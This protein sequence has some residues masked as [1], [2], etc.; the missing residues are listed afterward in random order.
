MSI[1]SVHPKCG[2]EIAGQRACHC[3]ACC[4]TFSGISLFDAHRSLRGGEHG[5][6]LDPSTLKGAELRD[7]VWSAPEMSAEARAAISRR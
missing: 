3:A 5:T 1:R 4:A 2:K 7:G 6:C